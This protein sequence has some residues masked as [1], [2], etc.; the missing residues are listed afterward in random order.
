M[1]D[2]IL[3]E[4]IPYFSPLFAFCEMH[5][6]ELIDGDNEFGP[7][8]VGR[9]CVAFLWS[10]QNL[11]IYR[12]PL[13]KSDHSAWYVPREAPGEPDFSY[14]DLERQQGSAHG[15]HLYVLW[16]KPTREGE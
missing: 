5:H 14:V 4:N 15:Y 7:K 9:K 12:V 13:R 16:P 2:A 8:G 10:K 1:S 11:P 6:D 3:V